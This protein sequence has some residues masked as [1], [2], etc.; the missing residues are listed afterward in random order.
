MTLNVESLKQR[1]K[2]CEDVFFKEYPGVQDDTPW[3]IIIY[4]K[5]MCDAV[6]MSETFLPVIYKEWEADKKAPDPEKLE[7]QLTLQKIQANEE[8]VIN[9]V[10][11]G[12]CV[13]LIPGDEY[14]YAFNAASEFNRT[15]Q[16]ATSEATIKGARDGFVENLTT[17]VALIRKRLK[18]TDLVYTSVDLGE[19]TPVSVG[20]LYLKERIVP[21]M[22][23]EIINK[24][25]SYSGDAPVGIGELTEHISPYRFSLFPI[26]DYSGRPDF[27]NDALLRGRLIM[28]LDGS[29]VVLI[30]PSNL[31]QLLFAAEDPHLPFYFVFPWRM[32]RLVAIMLSILL[33]GFYTSLMSYHQDQI[34]FPLLATIG[35][36]RSSLPF[37]LSVEMFVILFILSLLREAGSRMPSPVGGTITLV[38]GIIIGDAAIRGG[39]FSP[40]AIVIAA[41]SFV[42]GSTLANQDFVF[43]QTILR[44]LILL[45][46]SFLGL[47][48]F[49]ITIFLIINYT[50][51]L[52]PFGQPFLAPFSPFAPQRL[53]R[54]FMRIPGLRKKGGE[55]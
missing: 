28:I 5:M 48:G 45:M 27:A 34:P 8:K 14:C 49:F 1:F 3:G 20:I 41:M 40:T 31:M 42:A 23:E 2:D 15:P 43:T 53:L 47:F 55:L 18:T 4:N 16:D 44:F 51:H 39:L 22:A 24:L 19:I 29:P 13:I 32:L 25:K 30:A 12:T 46:S 9:L 26:F 21:Q 10:F 35:S 33:P 54:N 50:A 52:R 11:S 17:N 37:S 7:S 6:K 38:A 36:T